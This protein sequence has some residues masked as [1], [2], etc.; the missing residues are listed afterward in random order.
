MKTIKLL[1]VLMFSLLGWNIHAQTVAPE[2]NG[3]THFQRCGQVEYEKH[4]RVKDP[5]YDAKRHETEKT[6]AKKIIEMD[7][8]KRSVHPQPLTQYVIPVVFHVVYNGAAQNLTDQQV[9]YALTP[10]NQDWSRTNSDTGRTPAIWKSIAANMNVTFCL[11]MQDP[12]GAATTGII[13]KATT[14]S[15]FTTDDKVKS[16]ASGGDDA[17]DTHKYLNIWICNLGSSLLGYSAFPPILPTWGTVVHYISVGSL[18]HPN[19]AGGVYG[20]GRNLSHEIGHC[21]NLYHTW[22]DDAGACTGTDY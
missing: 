15:S 1:L 8:A 21:F 17:W 12:N 5:A 13:H 11:A 22:G 7:N 9:L 6:I 14:V 3:A 19:S 18:S 2:N 4:L 20:Y 10:L 16:S